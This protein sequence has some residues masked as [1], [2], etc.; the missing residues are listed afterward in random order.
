M[1]T[2]AH[3]ARE[4]LTAQSVVRYIE[5]DVVANPADFRARIWGDA[6][7]ANDRNRQFANFM[8]VKRRAFL[9]TA[10]GA[11]LAALGGCAAHD[12]SLSRCPT[13]LSDFERV[14]DLGA[15]PVFRYKNSSGP[16][17]VL[18]H[19]L[20]GMSLTNLALAKC[21]ARQVFS[22]YLPLLFGEAGQ[23]RFF[24]G[25]FQS[26]ARAEFDCSSLSNSSPILTSLREVCGKII[27]RTKGSMGVIGMCM[28][29]SFPLA[30]FRD[31]VGAAVLC[32]PT[33][34]FN[35]FLMRPVGQQKR[36][37]GLAQGDIERAR[38][39]KAPLLAIR[40]R[41]DPLCPQER[42]AALRETFPHRVATIEIDGEP[43]GHSTLAG[44]LN[45]GAFADAVAY[46]KTRLGLSKS[47]KKMSL[48]KFD[49]RPCEIT[50]DGQW[51]AL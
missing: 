18:L 6:A 1:S 45:E 10:F 48:A 43:Q 39:F 11:A 2:A 34:P 19:E 40:Y 12:R 21:L 13:A 38:H 41:S 3:A 25:Y 27:E 7:K 20:P 42:I 9:Q 37:L 23:E 4:K 30:L 8:D 50:A 17:L 51:R 26:C 15:L 24:F 44:D 32:Q 22:V 5:A 47:A 29:G 49:D 46:L 31:G 33:L 16:A 14:N 35:V 36:S 28:T